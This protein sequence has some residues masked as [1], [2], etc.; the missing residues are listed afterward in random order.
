MILFISIVH[1]NHSMK[2][3]NKLTLSPKLPFELWIEIYDHLS[4]AERFKINGLSKELDEV[5]MWSIKRM[6]QEE[7]LNNVSSKRAIEI[8]KELCIFRFNDIF[9]DFFTKNPLFSC[10]E[11]VGG[12]GDYWGYPMR[13]KGYALYLCFYY[14]N[15]ELFDRLMEH[16]DLI[17]FG[18]HRLQWIQLYAAGVDANFED[19]LFMK[20]KEEPSMKHDGIYMY[21][22]EGLL[23]GRNYKKLAKELLSKRT[24]FWFLLNDSGYFIENPYELCEIS[25]A[26]KHEVRRFFSEER[27]SHVFSSLQYKIKCSEISKN[28]NL[29]LQGKMS[30]SEF[31]KYVSELILEIEFL[32]TDFALEQFGKWVENDHK[33]CKH[34]KQ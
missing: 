13:L 21:F 8:L 10:E 22:I 29:Y 24:R 2:S 3:S 27:I 1:I 32:Y 18:K 31:N 25:E 9:I 5:R 6:Y 12:W 7:K 4:D 33:R 34:N 16:K 14:K 23:H 20:I 17:N 28:S 26:E 19:P 11:F 30:D 15:K